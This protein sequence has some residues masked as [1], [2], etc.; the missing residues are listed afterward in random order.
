MGHELKPRSGG[1]PSATEIAHLL[2]KE[3]VYVKTDAE[4]GMKQA[5]SRAD[6]IERAPAR[7][8]LGRHKEALEGAARLKNLAPGEA[9]TIEF[10][11]SPSKTKRIVVIPGEPINFGYASKEDEA[12]SKSLV[13]RCARALDSEVVLF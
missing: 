12:A 13:E 10:G 7:I 6:W 11:D 5:R 3:F 2:T 1:F 8:F 9:L 4:E